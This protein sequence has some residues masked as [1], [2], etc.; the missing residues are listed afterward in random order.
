MNE[1]APN[2]YVPVAQAIDRAVAVLFGGNTA[3]ELTAAEREHAALMLHQQWREGNLVAKVLMRDGSLRELGKHDVS[4]EVK[5]DDFVSGRVTVAEP[6]PSYGVILVPGGGTILI[7]A[8]SLDDA[9]ARKSAGRFTVTGIMFYPAPIEID[10]QSFPVVAEPTENGWRARVPALGVQ[11]SGA[12]LDDARVRAEAAARQEAA[13]AEALRQEEAQRAAQGRTHPTIWRIAER[14]AAEAE[15][16]MDT[17]SLAIEL[18]GAL[19]HSEIE[20]IYTRDGEPGGPAWWRFYELTDDSLHPPKNDETLLR[21]AREFRLPLAELARWCDR[22]EFEP[23][24]RAQGLRR[25]RF[26]DDGQEAGV[27]PSEK[28][29]INLASASPPQPSDR[30]RAE[31][32][33]LP[34][35]ERDAL[36]QAA[37]NKIWA[38]KPALSKI[39]VA[40]RLLAR[41]GSSGPADGR[42]Q[43]AASLKLREALKNRRDPDKEN[44]SPEAIAR[45]LRCR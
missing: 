40:K 4:G 43:D 38:E 34:A 11:V 37:A 42:R 12:S 31:S 21:I 30:E 44:L 17:E 14:W 39:D 24:A 6:S 45:I 18:V 25:P 33:T 28:G 7:D 15:P 26:L 36:L 22:P 19:M 20:Q 13:R 23:W 5:L 1:L 41:V 3:R 35:A 29:V 8:H 27:P 9:L 32:H 2:G 10:G 16:P